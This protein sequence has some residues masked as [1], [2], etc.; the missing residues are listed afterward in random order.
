MEMDFLLI[1]NAVIILLLLS[2]CIFLLHAYNKRKREYNK[3]EKRLSDQLEIEMESGRR[4]SEFFS[5][6]VHELKTPLSVLLG[7]I[8]LMELKKGD[9]A[10]FEN[11]FLKNMKIIKCNC[12]RMLRLINNLLDL[13][14]FEEGYLE[15]R[16]VNCDLNLLLDEIIQSV[17]PYAVQRKLDLRFD[18]PTEA[19]VSAIDLEKMERIMLNLLSNAIKF[20]GPGG[21]ITVSSYISGGR[22]FISVKDSGSGIPIKN[23]EEIF[24]RFRQLENSGSVNNKGS[25][26]GLSLVKSF[27]NL[28]HGNIRVISEE[29]RG[30]EFII[31]L[32]A[33]NSAEAVK[34]M[35]AE[36][37]SQFTEEVKI[38]LSDLYTAAL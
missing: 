32:P 23:Q 24:D 28:H 11:N 29:N 30:S 21:V 14:R 38:E 12:Y 7:A 31:D 35:P 33:Q 5:N 18:R 9:P 16:P 19:V 6:M 22:I 36:H 17:M 37:C 2:I 26:I 20:T 4:K 15:L 10:D 34:H 3:N 25:G 13:T 1:I 8:Q 27:V